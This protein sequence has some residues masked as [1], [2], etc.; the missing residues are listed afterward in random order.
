LRGARRAADLVKTV[1]LPNRLMKTS[2]TIT[3]TLL[4]CVI[5]AI[6]AIGIRRTRQVI[7]PPFRPVFVAPAGSDRHAM[8]QVSCCSEMEEITFIRVMGTVKNLSSSPL[9]NLIAEA[10]F[11]DSQHREIASTRG[12]LSRPV[13]MP[14]SVLRFELHTP[15][16]LRI[17]WFTVEV[18]RPGGGAVPASYRPLSPFENPSDFSDDGS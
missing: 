2:R 17:A 6:I 3:A 18:R 9:P 7:S 12:F 10:R 15:V 14:G 16:D 8:L 1:V 11:F 4:V 13:L 5:A